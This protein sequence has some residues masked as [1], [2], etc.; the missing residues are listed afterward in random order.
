MP[1]FQRNSPSGSGDVVTLL[2]VSASEGDHASLRHILTRSNWQLY[3]ACSCQE[4][5]ALFRQRRVP[6]VVCSGDLPDG[7]WKDLWA[8]LQQDANPPNLVVCSR[9]ADHRL[10]AEALNLGAYDILN[11][12]FDAG[13]VFQVGHLAWHAA[14]E[15]WR[16]A[17]ALPRVLAA[18][19]G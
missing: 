6:V 9:L 3:H 16:R 12:P 18:S 14:R 11:T 19:H 1:L 17:P 10:W 5:L 2:L 8:E 4:G 13:E 15:A 7:G